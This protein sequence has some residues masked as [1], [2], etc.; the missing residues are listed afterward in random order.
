MIQIEAQNDNDY[1]V[2]F[3]NPTYTAKIQPEIILFGCIDFKANI[4]A[5]LN[6][7]N[8]IYYSFDVSYFYS[9]FI[10]GFEYSEINRVYL[11]WS[12]NICNF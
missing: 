9:G 2:I 10:L 11:Q 6:N 1:N 7:M 5:E 4:S 12:I 8:K 3:S